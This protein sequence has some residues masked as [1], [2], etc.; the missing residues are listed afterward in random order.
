LDD[1]K[2]DVKIKLSALWAS[3][4][5]CYI[6]GD[7]FGF[8]KPGRL[9]AVLAGRMGPFQTTQG[10]LL[11]A[12]IVMAIP[13]VMV[14]LSLVLTPRLNRWANIVLGILYILIM[15]ATMLPGG[16]MFYLFLGTVE[17]ALSVLIVWHAWSWP[18]QAPQGNQS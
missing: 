17:I 3:V 10:A 18:R 5:F 9:Q 13:A 6:Y 16:W 11:S 4:M 2:I 12:A 14:F 7:I 8:F 1:A 15:L